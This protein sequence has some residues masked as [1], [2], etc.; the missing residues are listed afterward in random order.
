MLKGGQDQLVA[1]EVALLHAGERWCR[2]VPPLGDEHDEGQGLWRALEQFLREVAW[3]GCQG[4]LS[5]WMAILL[6]TPQ[7]SGSIPT[8]K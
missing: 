7:P 2:G 3:D 6:A 1:F 4:L 5:G 8:S